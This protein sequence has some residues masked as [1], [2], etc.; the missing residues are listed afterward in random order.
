MK[1]KPAKKKAKPAQKKAKPA[2]KKAK[3]AKKR[4]PPSGGLDLKAISRAWHAAGK[5]G[6]WIGFV[7]SH[8]KTGH[9]SKAK[10][11]HAPTPSPKAHK[12]RRRSSP[13]GG[14]PRI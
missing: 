13:S 9:H 10:A 14:M 3:T 1:K 12:P 6:T 11:H 2:K 5:P 7:K 4:K 8:A